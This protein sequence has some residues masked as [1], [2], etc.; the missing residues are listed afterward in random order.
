M[1]LQ[2][3]ECN[4][5]N[6]TAKDLTYSQFSEKFVWLE[7][8]KTWKI[9]EKDTSVGRIYHASPVCYALGLLDDD[10]NILTVQLR[11][12]F[13]DHMSQ[14]DFIWKRTWKLLADDIINKQRRLLQT[15]DVQLHNYPL[16]EIKRLLQRNGSS[17]RN[18]NT[19]PT[20]D[21]SLL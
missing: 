10:K 13:R 19:I 1:F 4:K 2:W 15:V 5:T 20:I 16:V 9:R 17:L 18:F 7:N 8:S 11:Q 14:P 12:A 21:Q 6:A 3:M